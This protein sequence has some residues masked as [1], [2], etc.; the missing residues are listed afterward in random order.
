MKALLVAAVSL[1]IL[2][3]SPA[4]ATPI[5]VAFS[6][7]VQAAR[8]EVA[9]DIV[10]GD[11]IVGSYTFDSATPNMSLNPANTGL[12][13]ATLTLTV[14]TMSFTQAAAEIFV[15]V[16][17]GEYLVTG[18]VNPP[19]A[20]ANGHQLNTYGLRT[21]APAEITTTDLPLAIPNA[22]DLD[23]SL[24]FGLPFVPPAG[25]VSASVSA[26]I[27]PSVPEPPSIALLLVGMIA[28]ISLRAGAANGRRTLMQGRSRQ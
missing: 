13:A 15:E 22:G 27:V 18:D 6:G 23:L 5:T 3:P 8:P 20:L 12:Y 16:D 11:S 21:S 10:A 26:A 1:C 14:G 7:T 28:L 9:P 17:S 24:L 2:L 19:G 4:G 25:D